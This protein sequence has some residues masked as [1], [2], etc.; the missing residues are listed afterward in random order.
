[1]KYSI[2]LL[3][4]TVFFFGCED[5]DVNPLTIVPCE[6]GYRVG[7]EIALPDGSAVEIL[8]VINSLC[9]CDVQCVWAGALTAVVTYE[10]KI[11]TLERPHTYIA[12]VGGELRQVTDFDSIITATGSVRL[13]SILS[14]EEKCGSD[15]QKNIRQEE[16]CVRME[17]R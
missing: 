16:Y 5:P 15:D 6:D 4:L 12:D 14:P 13:L 10:G 2:T 7:G 11:D 9:P 8:E 1:M 3:L 17:V